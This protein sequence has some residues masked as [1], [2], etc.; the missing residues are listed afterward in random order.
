[1]ETDLLARFQTSP[2]A[3]VMLQV[4]LTKGLRLL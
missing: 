4:T 2:A 1:M 3:L